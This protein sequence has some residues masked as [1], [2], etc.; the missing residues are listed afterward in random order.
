ML[1]SNPFL[2]LKIAVVTVRNSDKRRY[3][4][5]TVKE[6]A[7][8]IQESDKSIKRSGIIFDKNGSLQSVD[9]NQAAYDPLQYPLM[10]PTG[11]RGWDYNMIKL[12][13]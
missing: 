8:F 3:D 7:I 2:D 6:I 10:F 4:E 12:Q 13:L 5:P 11:L 9:F 1:K